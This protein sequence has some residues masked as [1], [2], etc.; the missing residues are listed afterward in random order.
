MKSNKNALKAKITK[1]ILKTVGNKSVKII[2]AEINTYYD[3]LIDELMDNDTMNHVPF[4]D[5]FTIE[6]DGDKFDRE[7]K[8]AIEQDEFGYIS[9]LFSFED[10]EYVEAE[11]SLGSIYYPKWPKNI[12]ESDAIVISILKEIVDENTES[13][14]SIERFYFHHFGEFDLILI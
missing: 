10:N 3:D 11:I 4:L 7:L 1:H 6:H 2:V 9:D 14:A 8:K 5:L 12:D 13:F